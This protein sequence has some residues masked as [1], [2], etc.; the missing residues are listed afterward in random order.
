MQVFKIPDTFGTEG[1]TNGFSKYLQQAAD[2]NLAWTWRSE[3]LVGIQSTAFEAREVVPDIV[4]R[5]IAKIA[6]DETDADLVRKH[7]FFTL[8]NLAA[9]GLVSEEAVDLSYELS[10]YLKNGSRFKKPEHKDVVSLAALLYLIRAEKENLG[11][12][13][14]DSVVS[15][16]QPAAELAQRLGCDDPSM[17]VGELEAHAM[18]IFQ[19]M[20][21]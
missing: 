9:V 10:S 7:A 6:A 15:S 21:R 4:V 19:R 13:A 3:H 14:D 2:P 17:T 16:S 20:N 5:D 1:H 18:N 12:V 11:I 8:I